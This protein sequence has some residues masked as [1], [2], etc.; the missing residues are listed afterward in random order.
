[1][2]ILRYNISMGKLIALA[3]IFFSLQAKA[4]WVIEPYLGYESGTLVQKDNASMDLSGKTTMNVMG[5]RL[6]YMLN[7]GIWFAADYMYGSSG[8]FKYDDALNGAN[9]LTNKADLGLSVGVDIKRKFRMYF[10]YVVDGRYRT[11]DDIVAGQE[12]VYT[13]GTSFKVGGG[14]VFAPWLATSL[15][16]Y[17]NTPLQYRNSDGTFK[18]SEILSAYSDSGIRFVI[19]APFEF[20]RK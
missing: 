6:G 16:Y 17:S 20:R 3:L 10:G 12:N 13:G 7:H 2:P 15:E 8:T 14:Y 1:M 9:Q 11:V 4:G 19:S 5:L 18:V